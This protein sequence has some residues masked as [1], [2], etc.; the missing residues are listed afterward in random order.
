MHLV[1]CKCGALHGHVLPGAPNSRVRCYCTDC[2]AFGRYFGKEAK[3]LDAQGGTEIVQVCQSR[4]C[5]DGGLEHLTAIRLTDKGMIRWYA[6]CCLTPIGNTMPDRKMS[7]IGLIHSC[8][9]K[10]S[11]DKD[12]GTGIASFSTS[13][14]IGE[15]KPQQRG[16]FG[17]I[18]R[19][20]RLVFMSRMLGRY[21]KSPLFDAVGVPIVEPRIL[22]SDELARLKTPT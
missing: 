1:K 21:K 15:P 5:F 12:F 13:E 3:V 10:S 18:L 6:S 2:Q 7:F 11:I 17:T 8:L 14:A 4:L 19:F 22:S 20:M 16:V 9:D